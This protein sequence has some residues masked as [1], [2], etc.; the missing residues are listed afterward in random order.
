MPTTLLILLLCCCAALVAGRLTMRLVVLLL[1]LG[2][3]EG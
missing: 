3:G 1:G 2:D